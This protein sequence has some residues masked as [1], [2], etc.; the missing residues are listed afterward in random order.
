MSDRRIYQ[1]VHVRTAGYTLLSYVR[2]YTSDGW[3][4]VAQGSEA[5]MDAARRGLSVTDTKPTTLTQ[6]GRS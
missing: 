2:K 3:T 5:A 4:Q 6:E 1:V